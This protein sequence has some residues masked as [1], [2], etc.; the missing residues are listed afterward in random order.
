MLWLILAGG[1]ILRVFM[2]WETHQ[3]ARGKA[4]LIDPAMLKNRVLRSGLTA[5]FFQYLLQAGLFFVVPLFLSVA[6]GLS[7]IATGVRLLPA[8]GDPSGGGRGHPEALP[9]RF[10]QTGRPAWDSSPCWPGS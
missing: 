6:L 10:A 2:W 7:A 4:A 3:L 9:A 1:V 8:F 5:F